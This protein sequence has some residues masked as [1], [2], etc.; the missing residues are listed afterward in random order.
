MTALHTQIAKS[1]HGTCL[2]VCCSVNN[3]YNVCAPA[4]PQV[5]CGE[6]ISNQHDVREANRLGEADAK[7][8]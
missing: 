1:V 8:K 4:T 5:E 6:C 7:S 3:F 2:L